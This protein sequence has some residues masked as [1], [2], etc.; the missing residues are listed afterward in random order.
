MISEEELIEKGI[1]INGN[2]DV[3]WG[4]GVQRPGII[5][6]RNRDGR[7]DWVHDFKR[8]LEDLWKYANDS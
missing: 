6:S 5:V 8:G 3:R 4:W 1:L 2:T 7:E